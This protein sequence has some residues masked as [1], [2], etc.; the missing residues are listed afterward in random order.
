MSAPFPFSFPV[1]REAARHGKLEIKI[2]ND[3]NK[4]MEILL[5]LE[6]CL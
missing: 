1:N 3:G 4:M 5:Q 2:R 6:E